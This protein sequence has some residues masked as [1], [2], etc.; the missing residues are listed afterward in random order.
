MTASLSIPDKNLTLALVE[1]L[2]NLGRVERL[3]QEDL[4]RLNKEY[5]LFWDGGVF[6]DDTGEVGKE[7]VLSEVGYNKANSWIE[8][9]YLEKA[10]SQEDLLQV[11]TLEWG[12][13]CD[14]TFDVF[15]YWDGEDGYFTLESLQ[16]IEHC[17]N[18]KKLVL[19]LGKIADLKPLTGLQSLEEVSISVL[20]TGDLSPLEHLPHLEKLDLDFFG[21]D[22]PWAADLK[23][24]ARLQT[25]KEVRIVGLTTTDLSPL[26][27]LP[28]LEKLRVDW[29][30]KVKDQ[31]S[32]SV[33]ARLAQRGGLSISSHLL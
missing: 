26:E 29:S 24:L 9:H 22:P 8:Q 17:Q 27:H 2:I 3:S 19:D 7:R 28:H 5:S 16:G 33:F 25:L 23:P 11:T 32:P 12:C 14:I 10:V 18:L 20:T 31:I 4:L 21:D 13:C 15:A 30:Y 6:T 1:A